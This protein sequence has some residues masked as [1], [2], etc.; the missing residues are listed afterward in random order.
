LATKIRRKIM[1]KIKIKKGKI[2]RK[3]LILILIK[4]KMTMD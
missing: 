1:R 3:D 2:W 4:I